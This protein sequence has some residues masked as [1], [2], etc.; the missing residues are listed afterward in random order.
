[1]LL[2]IFPA[3]VRTVLSEADLLI[4]RDM[5]HPHTFPYI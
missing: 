2:S 1:M 5:L 3:D 4:S